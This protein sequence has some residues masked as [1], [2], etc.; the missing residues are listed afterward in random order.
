M[1]DHQCCR[2]ISNTVLGVSILLS[3]LFYLFPLIYFSL[4]ED[5]LKRRVG[6][7]QTLL[8][9][10]KSVCAELHKLKTYFLHNHIILSQGACLVCKKYFNPS[11][12]LWNWGISSNSFL[13]LFVT[14]DW[15][16]IPN[17]CKIQIDSQW[18]WNDWA[19]EKHKPEKHQTP[20]SMESIQ[21]NNG[22]C[23][24]KHE[25]EEDFRQKVD[26]LVY[27]P[28]FWLRRVW[29][30]ICS[31]LSS[32]V[33]HH[34]NY[35]SLRCKYC[36]GPEGILELKSLSILCLWI[37]VFALELINMVSRRLSKDLPPNWRNVLRIIFL[38]N[39]SNCFPQLPISLSIKLVC[40]NKHWSRFLSG[41]KENQ[42]C[43]NSFIVVNLD[44]GA[45][46]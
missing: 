6:L 1:T 39:E 36:V 21:Y 43:R 24:E 18:N 34:S 5:V 14:I 16:R 35:V 45:N 4:L 40:S 7:P 37:F 12:F 23:K 31:C 9:F 42:I 32:C 13:D 44:E 25:D 19:E 28:Y 22:A 46:S 15:M 27:Q 8:H 26:L 33:C 17:L 11:K 10:I 30:H 2:Q 29:I 38:L 41:V 3:L 20:I